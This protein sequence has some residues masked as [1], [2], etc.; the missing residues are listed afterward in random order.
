MEIEIVRKS[1]LAARLGIS[2]PRVSQLVKA[3]MPVLQDGRV[4]LAAAR[5]WIAARVDPSH[6]SSRTG[7]EPPPTP[8][9]SLPR[10]IDPG[11]AILRAKA[12]IANMA[13]RAAQRKDRQAAGELVE[14][15]SV[16]E[17]IATFSRLVKDHIQTMPDRLLEQLIAAVAS[18]DRNAAY[19]M[20][21]SDCD[22]ILR[23][24]AKAIADTG[25]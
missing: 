9:Q 22:A 8:T 1:D 19:R 3:G 16:N 6:P 24:L 15:T 18:G 12:V 10:P 13:A 23:R 20:L 5:A 14:R 17:Y 21:R 11:E 25:L 4:E 7:R 2:R